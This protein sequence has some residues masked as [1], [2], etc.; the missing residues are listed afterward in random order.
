MLPRL[1]ILRVTR[2]QKD[3]LDAEKVRTGNS[4]AAI[5][6]LIVQKAMEESEKAKSE[7]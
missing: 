1:P 4:M 5:I 3:F 7:A 6:R 2:E